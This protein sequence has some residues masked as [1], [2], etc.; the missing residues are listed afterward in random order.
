MFS[1]EELSVIRQGLD[2]V[3]ITG[4]SAKRMVELQNKVETI[5]EK[6]MIKRDK[7]LEKV[8]NKQYLPHIY[9]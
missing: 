3:T 9:H 5:L 1:I 6:E 8:V 7:E 2:L 4:V